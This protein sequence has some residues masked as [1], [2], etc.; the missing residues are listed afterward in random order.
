M[1]QPPSP[2]RSAGFRDAILGGWY[3]KATGE[4]YRGFP[5]SADDVVLDVGCGQGGNALF[6]AQQ[7]A[8]IIFTDPEADKVQS[9]EARLLESPA[10]GWEGHV[11]DSRPLPVADNTATRIILSEVLEH[12]EKPEELLREVVRTGRSG[13]LFFLSVPD[14][15]GEELQKAVAPAAHFLPPNHVN[16]FSREA[17]AA[18]VQEAGLVVEQH[19]FYG[20]YWSVWMTLYWATQRASGVLMDGATRDQL[21]PPFHP[22]LDRWALLWQDMLNLPDGKLLREQFDAILPKNQIIVARKP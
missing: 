15:L 2:S 16:I 13:A 21:E 4:L 6:C 12:V 22:L 1:T 17:F 8:Y 9:L 11:S 19:R 10:C 20:F 5:V 18:L 7:G 14:A 3:Q